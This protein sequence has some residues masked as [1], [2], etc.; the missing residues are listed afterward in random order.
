MNAVKRPRVRTLDELRPLVREGRYRI[1]SHALKH[2]FCEGFTENDMVGSV[3]YG[4]ELVRYLQDERLL[5]LGYLKPSPDVNIPLHVVLEYSKPRWVDIVTAFIP[6]DAHRVVS[7][8]RLA[9]M[10]RYDRD[11]RDSKQVGR[12]RTL[13]AEL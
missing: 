13:E 6:R 4:R 2:A 1:G 8:A 9:E 12:R 3:L 11:T 10:L 5:A 7:R